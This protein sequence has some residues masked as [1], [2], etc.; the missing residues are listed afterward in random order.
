MAIVLVV[1]DHPTNRELVV[2]L[3]E[4]RGHRA[5]EA[6]DGADALRLARA[7]RPQL[8]ISDILMPT[9]DG[10]ELVRQL[11]ADPQLAH[12]NVI[13]YTAHYHERE[14]RSLA[15]S[16]GVSHVLIKPC[17]PSVILDAIDQAL[18]GV[19]QAASKPVEREF[20]RDHLRL[21]T[22]KLSQKV[23]ELVAAN[24][25]LA[26][27]TEVNLR[28]A[29]ERDPRLLLE[30]V[31]RSARDLVGARYAVLCMRGKPDADPEFSTTSGIDAA[32]LEKLPSPRLDARPFAPVLA[33][34]RNLRFANPGGDPRAAGLPAGYPPAASVLAAPV[35]SPS[36][37][38]GWIGLFDKLGRDAFDEEDERVL[39]SLASQ[40]GRIY[41]NS[42]IY[43]EMKRKAE[44]LRESELWFRELAENIP[45]VFFLVDPARTQTLYV[46]PAYEEVWGRS[47]DE[48]YADTNSWSNAIVPEDRER[49][50]A[51]QRAGSG[52]TTFESEFRIARPDGGVRWI[53]ARGFP[54]ADE[55]GN[56]YRVAG[57]AEDITE[58]K[59]LENALYAS[60]AG[61]RRAQSLARLGHVITRPDGS[62]ESW[63]ETMPHLVGRDDA[64]MPRTTRKW[65]D[66]VHADDR[67][68]FR[69]KA[70]EAGVN[71][72]RTEIEY[73]VPVDGHETAVRQVMEP[74][75]PA[76][77]DGTIRWFSTLQD[78]TEQKRAEEEV[79]RL[80]AGLERR[81][82]ER[83][84]ELEAANRELE[85]FDYSVSHELRAPLSHIQGFSDMLLEQYAPSLDPRGQDLLRRIG[86]AGRRMDQLVG[87]LF[88]LSTVARGE[89]RRS[90]V[91]ASALARSVGDALRKAAPQHD[92]DFRVA[93]G[94][95]ARADP[96]LLRVVLE[97]LLGNAWKFTSRR[98]GAR[99]EVGAIEKDGQQFFFV[100]DNGA[101]YDPAGAV[102]LFSPFQRLH[103]RSEFEGT[104][105]G[106]ATVQ[107]IIRRHGGRVWG[108]SVPG[109]GATF[110]FTLSP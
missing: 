66:I 2:T 63:S 105:V 4:H 60:E 87:D 25:R 61:L 24:E 19:P 18:A 26:A 92:V 70:I 79:R 65:L 23:E 40:V 88:A 58:R 110:H 14:A 48:V 85:A 86:G 44:E 72:R 5:L 6:A 96:G 67:A 9:M 53:R 57:I 3:L 109:E 29:S 106:L 97:N 74:L 36:R 15:R 16:C 100:R 90:D 51:E 32:I 81:V 46:S 17:E 103:S 94:L 49:A 50:L 80:N 84:A 68:A 47:I 33:E 64:T 8:V 95:T 71:R 69:A 102:R 52:S 42:S 13:F 62:F 56:T 91:D 11:R 35:A 7:Q 93:P 77:P 27:L 41:E 73:R 82:A 10:F 43:L 75:G 37:N 78:V 107:R 104:G 108:E 76:G 38:Y 89:L 30:S 28:L 1:D 22:D 83:T 31:C 101:G 54:I 99:V 12:T 45:Q 39:T 21:M 59:R 34:G 55:H 20:D 98:E